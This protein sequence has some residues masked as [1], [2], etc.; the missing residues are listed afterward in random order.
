[1]GKSFEFWTSNDTP[2]ASQTTLMCNDYKLTC[3]GVDLGTP[4]LASCQSTATADLQGMI[5]FYLSSN[6]ILCLNPVEMEKTCFQHCLIMQK[7]IYEFVCSN[8]ML[9]MGFNRYKIKFV[10]INESGMGF[11]IQSHPYS[12]KMWRR[13][14]SNIL[15]AKIQTMLKLLEFQN[16]TARPGQAILPYALPV[17]CLF[18]S[19]FDYIQSKTRLVPNQSINH[20]SNIFIMNF[21]SSTIDPHFYHTFNALILSSPPKNFIT[22]P[23]WPHGLPRAS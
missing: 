6:K 11:S 4:Y 12:W 3:Y 2:V 10:S 9:L 14:N 5:S 8:C 19:R 13:M 23:A 22:F 15:T 21:F 16:P 20:C 7:I 17:W 1:M 18:L